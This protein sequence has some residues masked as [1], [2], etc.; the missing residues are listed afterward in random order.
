MKSCQRSSEISTKLLHLTLETKQFHLIHAV[1]LE[2]PAKNN[3]PE[4]FA[5]FHMC[6]RA[7]DE[8]LIAYAGGFQWCRLAVTDLQEPGCRCNVRMFQRDD[9]HPVLH[10]RLFLSVK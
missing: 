10:E 4:R 6:F 1:V 3:L 7:I 8:K 5:V 2:I 9:G